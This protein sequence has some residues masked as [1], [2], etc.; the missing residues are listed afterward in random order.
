MQMHDWFDSKHEHSNE[1]EM[2]QEKS[3]EGDDREQGVGRSQSWVS[4]EGG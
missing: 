3:G 1:T 2:R 4:G